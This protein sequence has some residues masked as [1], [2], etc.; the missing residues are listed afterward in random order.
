MVL[1]VDDI[2]G[3][4]VCVQGVLE[5]GTDKFDKKERGALG[6]IQ[7]E[8][9]LRNLKVIE[10]RATL[11]VTVL[12]DEKDHSEDL[13]AEVFRADGFCSQCKGISEHFLDIG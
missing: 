5:R 4:L 3:D 10:V 6:E 7:S 8:L 1:F 2:K 9:T 13:G 11:L 12:I